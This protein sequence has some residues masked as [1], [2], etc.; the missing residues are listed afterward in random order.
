MAE[1]KDFF[2]IPVLVQLK[3][4][5][6]LT[7]VLGKS[8]IPYSDKPEESQWIPEESM[9]GPP[10]TNS[11][12]NATQLVRFAVLHPTTADAIIEMI[13]MCPGSQAGDAV[14]VATLVDLENIAYVSRVMEVHRGAPPEPKIILA[15]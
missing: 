10:G 8:V 5:L 9:S 3:E 12:P 7:R 15:P 13:W 4:P 2:G 6:V 1:I 11:P 14:Q